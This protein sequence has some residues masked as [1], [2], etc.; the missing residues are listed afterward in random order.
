M[1]RGYRQ[2]SNIDLFKFIFAIVVVMIHT[3]P[4]KDVSKTTDWYFNNTFANLAVPFF[5]VASGFL[6]FDKLDGIRENEVKR[7]K[8][9]TVHLLRMFVTW[10]IIWLPW[11]ILHFMNVNFASDVV[12]KY[13]KNLIL[14]GGGGG[15]IWYLP[16]LVI[17][18]V[19]VYFMHTRIKSPTLTV[20]ISLIPYIIG[21]L[22]S[23]WYE[24]FKDK[25]IIDL[26]YK[27][28]A[29]VDNGVMLG[30]MF[31]AIG[32]Y[33][34]RV[35]PQGHKTKDLILCFSFF[36]LL[37]AEVILIKKMGYNKN[38]VCNPVTLPFVTYYLFKL[39]L[40]VNLRDSKI[41]AKLRDYSTLIFLSH[42]II[43]KLLNTA[44]A[45]INIEVSSAVVF[46]ITITLSLTFA[47]VVRYFAK[48]RNLKFFKLLY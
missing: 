16:A 13:I 42:G 34:S 39:I 12:L 27:D 33:I 29:T 37:V 21:V 41:Y 7:I 48:E 26:F 6:L 25:T 28:F 47:I 4:F 43:I 18:I 3:T 45:I 35:K 31:V 20:I 17:A 14:V 38:G 30:V 44:F 23:S 32:M 10:S 15:A 46:I 2:Y 22:I 5:F 19:I 9:Y 36:L 40:S 11:N 8:K 24:I 1:T